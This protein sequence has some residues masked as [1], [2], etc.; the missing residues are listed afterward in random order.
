MADE[1]DDA[2]MSRWA[3][4]LMLMLMPMLKRWAYENPVIGI[5]KFGLVKNLLVSVKILALPKKKDKVDKAKVV[6]EKV[7]KV[8]KHKVDND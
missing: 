1:D 7:D 2:Q 6:N 4:E 3:D 5:K 8:D